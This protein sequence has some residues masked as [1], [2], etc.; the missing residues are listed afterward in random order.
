MS[1][2][3]S[4]SSL[5]R[6]RLVATT[7]TAAAT[8]GETA[9]TTATTTPREAA[10]ATATA[11][12]AE[13][14]TA[15]AG[16]ATT[17][18]AGETTA[19][20]AREAATAATAGTAS[21]TATT[22][23][24]TTASLLH[25]G[26]AENLGL[27]EETLEREE[28]LGADEN[29][30]AGLKGSSDDAGL[31]L[32]GEVDLKEGGV[33]IRCALVHVSEGSTHLVERT[34]DLIDLA[35]GGLVLEEDL[36]VEMGDLGVGGLVEHLALDGVLEGAEL[37]NLGGGTIVALTETTTA[38][39]CRISM[40]VVIEHCERSVGEKVNRSEWRQWLTAKCDQ[41]DDIKV[42]DNG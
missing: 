21:G 1:S 27:G 37:E 17:T 9:A 34:E 41:S 33:L 2:S 16:E 31:G 13:T 12:P 28:L 8:A 7:T 4:S 26:G 23:S 40:L 6:N 25:L 42:C 18:P 5:L 15:A 14:T 3:S 38:A 30:V 19:A 22:T 29:L 35:D 20:A 11:T 10:A 36:S 32:D 24:T 39:C